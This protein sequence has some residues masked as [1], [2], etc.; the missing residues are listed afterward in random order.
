LMP[1]VVSSLFRAMPY[2]YV[3]WRLFNTKV[4]NWRRARLGF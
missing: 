2:E 4:A 1:R 3:Q